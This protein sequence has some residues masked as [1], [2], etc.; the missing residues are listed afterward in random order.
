[1]AGKIVV[2]PDTTGL[3]GM[4]YPSVP[5][6]AV[7]RDGGWEDGVVVMIDQ[8]CC[9]PTRCSSRRNHHEVAAA[10]RYMAI[11]GAPAIG[12]AAAFGL[13]LGARTAGAR[14]RHSAPM[15]RHLR[16]HGHHAPDGG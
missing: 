12:V 14:G 16:D 1:M 11:R 5:E 2:S 3:L 9:P 6:V 7:G 13:A 15:E 4:A 10:I 8:R